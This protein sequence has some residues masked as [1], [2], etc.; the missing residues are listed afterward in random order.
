[1]W[2]CVPYV[3][4]FELHDDEHLVHRTQKASHLRKGAA[5]RSTRILPNMGVSLVRGPPNW[6]VVLFASLQSRTERQ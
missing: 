4:P 3:I 2:I 6:H 1:M 5:Q